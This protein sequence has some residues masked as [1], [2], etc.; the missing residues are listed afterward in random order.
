MKHHLPPDDDYDGLTDCSL[1]YLGMG[2]ALMSIYPTFSK[3]VYECDQ[4]LSKNGFP[5]CL[6]IIMGDKGDDGETNISQMQAFQSAMFVLEV[7]LAKL[8]ISWNIL[9]VAVIGHR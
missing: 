2:R 8:L 3:I 5:G 6:D 9:P 4:L 7:A 1:Q